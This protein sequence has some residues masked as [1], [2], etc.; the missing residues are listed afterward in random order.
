MR[1][2]GRPHLIPIWFVWHEGKV[3]ICTP[4]DSQK[5]IN[6]NKNPQVAVAL[7]EGTH[8]VILEGTA[9]LREEASMRDALAPVFERKYEWDFR[10]DDEADYHLVEITPSKILS[11]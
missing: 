7:E 10:T 9:V 11:W 2:D 8:P 6:I 4:K 5:V 3:W 1:A